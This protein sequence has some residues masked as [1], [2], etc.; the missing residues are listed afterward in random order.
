MVLGSRTHTAG[1]VRRWT[2]DYD[3]W[4]DNTATIEQFTAA[5]SS[6]TCTIGQTSI[7]GHQAIF[8]LSGGIVNEQLTVTLVMTD[9]LGNIKNDT[10]NFTVVAP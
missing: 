6:A 4:L 1:D 8:F 9:S 10:I 5:S 3:A 2:I 7:L